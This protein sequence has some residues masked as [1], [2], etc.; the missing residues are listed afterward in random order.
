MKESICLSITAAAI[1][2]CYLG[3]IIY[4]EESFSKILYIFLYEIIIGALSFF[5]LMIYLTIYDY[6][7]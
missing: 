6:W 3:F 2:F 5:F 4:W 1:A 7:L